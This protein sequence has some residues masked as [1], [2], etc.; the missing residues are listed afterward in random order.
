LGGQC[1]EKKIGRTDRNIPIFP[2]KFFQSIG[3]KNRT[4]AKKQIHFLYVC[5]NKAFS[6]K[7]CLGLS[8]PSREQC[9]NFVNVLVGVFSRRSDRVSVTLFVCKPMR[10]RSG[11]FLK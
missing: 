5:V 6:Q 11:V 8:V 1:Y 7:S 10:L 9:Y 3:Q 2:S 4:D